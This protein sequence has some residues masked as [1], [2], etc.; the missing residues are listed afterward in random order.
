MKQRRKEQKLCRKMKADGRNG[1][2]KATPDFQERKW[3]ITCTDII[4][5]KMRQLFKVGSLFFIHLIKLLSYPVTISY[6]Y[7]YLFIVA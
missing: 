6:N 4:F 2:R 7:N 5:M 1:G 3:R